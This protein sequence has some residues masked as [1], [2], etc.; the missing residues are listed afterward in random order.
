MQVKVTKVCFPIYSYE[1][2]K[3]DNFSTKDTT[4]EFILYPKC[5]LFGGSAVITEPLHVHVQ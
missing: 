1:P 5:P 3:E 4:A 2:P